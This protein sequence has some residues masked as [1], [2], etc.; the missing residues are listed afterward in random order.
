[1]IKHLVLS[2]G[3]VVSCNMACAAVAVMDNAELASVVVETQQ[4]Q[5]QPVLPEYNANGQIG[6]VVGAAIPVNVSTPVVN[7]N[8]QPVEQPLSPQLMMQLNQ[9]LNLAMQSK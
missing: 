9:L 2:I 4:E 3:L 7:L 8:V 6:G 1:M 5:L